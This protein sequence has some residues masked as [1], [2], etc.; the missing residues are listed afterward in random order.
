MDHYDLNFCVNREVRRIPKG[1]QH[2]S[3]KHGRFIP[4]LSRRDYDDL[5]QTLEPDEPRP[6]LL[7]MPPIAGL[8]P[9]RLEIMAYETTTEGT[10]IS[11]A[12]PDTREGKLA[13]VNWCAEHV[14]VFGRNRAS[15]E[16]W[17]AV[18]F[19]R[20]PA[21]VTDDGRVEIGY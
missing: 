12:F 2:P 21:F 11:P 9:D 6:K 15:A 5:L 4:H 20:E 17:A 19:G 7:P 3:D 13:L 14:A 16:T 8:A 18:L 10:P 1:W